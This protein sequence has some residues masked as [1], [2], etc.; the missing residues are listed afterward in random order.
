[1][2][3]GL[4]SSHIFTRISAC[5][6]PGVRFNTQLLFSQELKENKSWGE[7]EITR[8]QRKQILGRAGDQDSRYRI[9]L[10]KVNLVQDK[11]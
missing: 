9:T 10:F 3:G 11:I 2:N 1:M 6:K 5:V 4:P 8:T 7:Q